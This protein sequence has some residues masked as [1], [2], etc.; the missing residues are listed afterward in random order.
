MLAFALHKG[1][2][3]RENNITFIQFYFYYLIK[4]IIFFL[5]F[6]CVDYYCSHANYFHANCFTEYNR[7]EIW[8]RRKSNIG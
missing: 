7:N 2:I 3:I 4:K 6:L 8:V 5:N 1:N